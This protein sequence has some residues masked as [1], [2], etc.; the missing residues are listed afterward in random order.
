MEYRIAQNVGGIK[1][2]RISKILHWQRKL[3]RITYFGDL[4]EM[5]DGHQETGVGGVKLWRISENNEK[6]YLH[7]TKRK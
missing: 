2:W 6:I 1:L 4:A 5:S 7:Y 3:W